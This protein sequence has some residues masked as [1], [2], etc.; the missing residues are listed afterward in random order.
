MDYLQLA[1]GCVSMRPGED[2]YWI[3]RNVS[4]AKLAVKI[5]TSSVKAYRMLPV[6][7]VLDHNQ[8]IALFVECVKVCASLASHCRH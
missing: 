5:K 6:Y 4:D 2:G 3:L 1:E 7:A 8:Q